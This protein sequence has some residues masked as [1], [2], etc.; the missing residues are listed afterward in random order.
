MALSDTFDVHHSCLGDASAFGSLDEVVDR[1]ETFLR[2][3][4][5]KIIGNLRGW[6]A[7][8]PKRHNEKFIASKL[9]NELNFN[10]PDGLFHFH[11]EDPENESATRTLDWG[12]YPKPALSVCGYSF[13]AQDRLY[14][15]EA[16]RFPT[17]EGSI[18]A[19]EREREYVVGDWE[20][21]HLDDKRLSGG[22]ERFKEGKHGVDL[23]RGGMIAFVQREP[24]TH[25]FAE[26][27]QWIA[28]L[29]SHPLKSHQ[30]KWT[31]HD[32]LVS[33]PAPGTGV[34][35]Y[36]SAH[37]RPDGSVVELRHFWL[38]LTAA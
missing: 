19:R 27:N 11:S 25:W 34:T 29:I 26:A 3:T 1:I 31:E 36:S 14:G 35:E 32:Q 17:H 15:I 18:D 30:A 24:A 22:I 33:H 16:K 20:G 13:G 2:E 12:V 28:D 38:D 23:E 8:K 5:P 10:A 6:K 37:D 9:S 4:L 21:K 7:G